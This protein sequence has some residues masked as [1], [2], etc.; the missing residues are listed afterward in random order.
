MP[1]T[2]DYNHRKKNMCTHGTHAQRYKECHLL[3][4]VYFKRETNKMPN[5]QEQSFWVIVV[6]GTSSLL[7]GLWHPMYDS[8]SH[9]FQFR[10]CENKRHYCEKPNQGRGNKNKACVNTSRTVRTHAECFVFDARAEGRMCPVCGLMSLSA[11]RA[12]G[13]C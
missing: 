9:V 5:L 11:T 13:S 1:S 3:E 4:M 8:H 7:G 10:V 2:T 6:C 12:C